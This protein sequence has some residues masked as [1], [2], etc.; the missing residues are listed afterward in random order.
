ML[1]TVAA[2]A[3]NVPPAL[4]DPNHSGNVASGDSFIAPLLQPPGCLPPGLSA[5]Y[6]V[7]FRLLTP[8]VLRHRH[9]NG[10]YCSREEAASD[11]K[12][13][14]VVEPGIVADVK[15]IDGGHLVVEYNIPDWTFYQ[16]F[17]SDDEAQQN[18]NRLQNKFPGL[19]ATIVSSGP[20]PE[21]GP[22]IFE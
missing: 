6:R 3:Q 8:Q 21:P 2:H 4:S 9:A 18:A 16:E 20:T 15:E 1:A 13:L 10:L 12:L 22:V 17:N 11:A 5:T 14:M 19:E 7:Y